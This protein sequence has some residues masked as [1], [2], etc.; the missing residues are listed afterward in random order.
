MIVVREIKTKVEVERIVISQE[1]TEILILRK[2]QKIIHKRKV[3]K[4]VLII[5]KPIRMRQT[6]EKGAILISNLIRKEVLK[7]ILKG[8]VK[9]KRLWKKI[10]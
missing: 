9:P 4:R 3:I 5:I 8:V 6:I 10:K 7:Q 2:I 1:M